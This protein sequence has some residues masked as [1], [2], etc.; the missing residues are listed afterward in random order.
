M[1]PLQNE[2]LY[3][4][5][6]AHCQSKS[7]VTESATAVCMLLKNHQ[8]GTAERSFRSSKKTCGGGSL[9]VLDNTILD[10]DFGLNVK[11][12]ASTDFFNSNN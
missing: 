6:Y 2:G 11:V 1:S 5:C 12:R 7:T 9:V 4:E 8:S 10:K 3:L